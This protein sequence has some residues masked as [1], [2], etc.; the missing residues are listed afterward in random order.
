MSADNKI[1]CIVGPTASGKTAFAIEVAKQI[2]GEIICADSMQIYK[3]FSIAT[4]KPTLE[5]RAKV[6][7]HLCDFLEPS[8]EFSVAKYVELADLA[9]EDIK[10]R[11]KTPLITGGTGL[12]IDSLVKGNKFAVKI[13][14][15]DE[16]RE[17]Y[18]NIAREK[19][20]IYLHNLLKDIDL[21]SYEKLYP[22]DVK[23]VVRAIEVYELTGKT[24][25]EHNL[26]T[27]KIPDKYDACMIGVNTLNRDE[28]Y[29]RINLRV[30]KMLDE[31]L[32]FEA[33][34]V[35]EIKNIEKTA[36]GAIGYKELKPYFDGV[37]SVEQCVD[38][39]KQESRRYAKR[40][41][42]WFRKNQNT[43]WIMRENDEKMLCDALKII[44]EHF[45]E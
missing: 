40:Q 20:N 33:K 1:L 28:L 14:N 12:Y 10:S 41:L 32:I 26:E 27:K 13:E 25:S 37:S 4:A 43:K 45:D 3:K 39:I 11:G 38:K 17:K 35:F 5:E 9:I 24:I 16:I 18:E 23:R 22:N 21:E 6:T 31:G 36:M 42:T 29:D 7:H 30:D 44:K 15:S 8:E 34:M 2:D 19:G